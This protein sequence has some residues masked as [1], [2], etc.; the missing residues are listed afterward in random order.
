LNS[1]CQAFLDL[2]M[3]GYERLGRFISENPEIVSQTEISSLT[4]QALAE[5]RAG[6]KKT[7][8]TCIHHAILLKMC[9]SLEI[10]RRGPFFKRMSDNDSDTFLDVFADIKTAYANLQ[11]AVSG[12]TMS[13]HNADP[14]SQV[15]RPPLISQ[16]SFGTRHKP[17]TD[18]TSLASDLAKVSLGPP[19]G[20]VISFS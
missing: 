1:L 2:G 8:Q 12:A 16:E 13:V 6:R 3:G 14:P 9:R 4:N 17:E 15:A 5:E 7:A 11:A 18:A 19:Q 20:K 10:K